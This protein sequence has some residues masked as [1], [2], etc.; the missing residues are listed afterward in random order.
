MMTVIEELR[1]TMDDLGADFAREMAEP[2]VNSKR[3]A[4]D[5]V[6]ALAYATRRVI[7]QVHVVV[8]DVQV[9]VGSGRG[10]FPVSQPRI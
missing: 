8:K 3:P 1:G 5:G 4:A 10:D 2:Q 6:E 7:S 9:G